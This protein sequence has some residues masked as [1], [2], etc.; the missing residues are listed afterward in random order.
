MSG[1]TNIYGKFICVVC[2]EKDGSQ[3]VEAVPFNWF[4][5]NYVYWPRSKKNRKKQ[6]QL[7]F[8]ANFSDTKEWEPCRML[9]LK[10]VYDY[11]DA[12]SDAAKKLSQFEDTDEENRNITNISRTRQQYH[13]QEKSPNAYESIMSAQSQH[14]PISSH[15][16]QSSTSNFQPGQSLQPST[17]S[18]QSLQPFVSLTPLPNISPTPHTMPFQTQSFNTEQNKTTN[19][20]QIIG[21]EIYIPFGADNVQNIASSTEGDVDLPN[22]EELLQFL[23]S[24]SS[25]AKGKLSIIT[26]LITEHNG[27]YRS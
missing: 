16:T 17:S 1:E 22:E 12:A 27:T 19:S 8:P 3:F 21:E 13:Q 15:L 7:D 24:N 20:I 23:K 11:Y 2:E 25:E 4:S 10:G 14:Q 26:Y 18:L 6:C 9:S 5:D